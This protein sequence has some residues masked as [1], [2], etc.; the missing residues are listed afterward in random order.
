MINV[1]LY[2][3]SA[4]DAESEK[5]VQAALDNASKGRTTLAI[6]HRLSTIQKAD[7][8]F[9]FKKGTDKDIVSI[10]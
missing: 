3:S 2:I 5:F 10:M 9:V 8:I 1:N 7:I 6:A 4:L